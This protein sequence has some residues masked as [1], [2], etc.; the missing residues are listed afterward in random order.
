M[1][2]RARSMNAPKGRPRGLPWNSAMV[3]SLSSAAPG[4]GRERQHGR[5]I[6]TRAAPVQ[7]WEDPAGPAAPTWDF[8]CVKAMQAGFCSRLACIHQPGPHHP[9]HVGGPADDVAAPHILMKKGVCCAADGSDVRPGY[10]L[11]LACGEGAGK[12]G[13]A[14]GCASAM[15]RYIRQHSSA[16]GRPSRRCTPCVIGTR[17][18]Q[19]ARAC[20][21]RGEDDVGHL[22]GASNVAPHLGGRR[23]RPQ[24]GA[25]PHVPR[26][27]LNLLAA[28]GARVC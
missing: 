22:L 10:G 26:A 21:P 1:V 18:L 16:A 14:A 11:G 5:A 3:A 24:K 2:T 20:C 19:K 23:H 6:R 15:A 17:P 4:A 9:A 13:A 28:A 8:R 12:A 7:R 25:P 27:Q